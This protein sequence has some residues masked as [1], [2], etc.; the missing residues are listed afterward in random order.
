[1]TI[2]KSLTNIGSSAFCDCINLSI[3]YINGNK[4]TWFGISFGNSSANPLHNSGLLYLNGKLVKD[5]II[6]E[7]ITSINDYAFFYCKSLKSIEIP[8]S[9]KSIG[10]LAFYECSLNKITSY[11][12]EPPQCS[13]SAFDSY[14]KNNSILEVPDN[15]IIKYETAN[16]WKDFLNMSGVE[17]VT[18][19][20]E[21]SVRCENGEIIVIGADENADMEVYSVNGVQVYNGVIK[22]LQVPTGVYIVNVLG[23][24]FK[25]VVL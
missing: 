13:E 4:T 5:L 21:I 12:V 8:N 9:V 22:M 7:G 23:K 20:N 6:P 14:T 16:G 19:D 24:S 1:M 18:K 10:D 3:V 25:V 11:A 15:S 2:G 17:S